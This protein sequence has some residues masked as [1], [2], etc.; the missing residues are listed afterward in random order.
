MSSE[1]QRRAE[2]ELLMVDDAEF[3]R[4]LTQLP[5]QME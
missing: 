1:I 4:L 2:T 3:N 5:K